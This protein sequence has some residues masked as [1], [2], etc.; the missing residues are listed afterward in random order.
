MLTLRLVPS[1]EITTEILERLWQDVLPYAAEEIQRMGSQE[2]L[3]QTLFDLR[4]FPVVKYEVDGFVVGIA[5]TIIKE[6]EGKNY[7]FY[8]FPFYGK[9]QNG[10]RAWFYSEENQREGY[11][12]L[13]RE[14]LS[15]IMVVQNPLDKVTKA[16]TTHLGSFN[17]YFKPVRYLDEKTAG[18][19]LTDQSLII[20]LYELLEE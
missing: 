2:A 15:G 14:N 5:S 20:C 11:E 16:S 1:S 4:D 18:L 9:D 17:K 19:L 6:F 8:R 12:M 10:S 3:K 13:K 7:L